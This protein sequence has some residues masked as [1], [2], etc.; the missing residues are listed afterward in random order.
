MIQRYLDGILS[1]LNF[2]NNAIR[3]DSGGNSSQVV[4]NLL[5]TSHA[6]ELELL[7][8]LELIDLAN[9]N[10]QSFASFISYYDDW[11]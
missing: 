7:G 8:V 4:N 2:I 9:I 6:V 5:Q 1:Q 11:R 10:T 3:R